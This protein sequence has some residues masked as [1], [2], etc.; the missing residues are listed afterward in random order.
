M[1]KI[2]WVGE[3]RNEFR[4]EL[5]RDDGK[6]GR[7]GGARGITGKAGARGGGRGG[8]REHDTGGTGGRASNGQMWRTTEAKW[9]GRKDG[10]A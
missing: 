6:E 4:R 8:R 1:G 7:V 3:G 2:G 10:I 9:E 5:G